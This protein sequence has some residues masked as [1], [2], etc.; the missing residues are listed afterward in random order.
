MVSSRIVVFMRRI[1]MEMIRLAGFCL[2]LAAAVCYGADIGVVT[3]VDGGARVLRGPNWYKLV[4]GARVQD[5]DLI[6]AAERAQVQVELSSGPVVNFAGPAGSLVISAGSREAKS[7]AEVYLP[8]GWLKFAVRQG[9]T[10]LRVR[11]NSGAFAASDAVAVV[12]A[13]AD[14]IEAFVETGNGK[15]YEPGK[16]GADGAHDV[17]SGEFAL[18]AADRPF[19]TAGAAPLKFVGAMPRHFRDP[20]PARASQY[21]VERVQLVVDRPISYAEAEPWLTGP[22]RRVFIRRLQP[23][24]SDPEFR[25]AAMAKPQAYPE[26]QA[27]I[28][29][30][31]PVKAEPGKT[32]AA[33]SEPPKAPEKPPSIFRWPFGDNKK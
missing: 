6:D 31:E 28:A 8:R 11:T 27:A 14:A 23:R 24:L 7:S 1:T 4:E 22:Y 13:D 17:K 9:S 15:M 32:E 19:A 25:T 20:L 29:P 3:V 10:A 18:R 33:K 16:A 30:S 26:W 5:G 12:H 2:L 21:S